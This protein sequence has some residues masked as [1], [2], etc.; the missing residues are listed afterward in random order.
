MSEADWYWEEEGTRRGPESA[1]DLRRHR[2]AGRIA[3]DTLVWRAGFADW[4]P[5]SQCELA[6]PAKKPPPL[7]SSRGSTPPPTPSAEG[8]LTAVPPTYSEPVRE[9]TP[10]PDYHPRFGNSLERAW[11]LWKTDFWPYV[12]M[13][14]LMSLILGLAAQFFVT[15]FFLSLPIMAG[16]FWW[17]LKRHRG[18]RTSVEDLFFGF[19]RRFGDLA[20]LNLILSVPAIVLVLP[21]MVGLVLAIVGLEEPGPWN[22]LTITGFLLVGI[23]ALVF[24]VFVNAIGAISTLASL[25]ILDADLPWKTALGMTWKMAKPRLARLTAIYFGYG[26]ISYLGIFVFYV[27]A[28]LAGTWS[29]TAL[30]LLYEDA[31]G[32]REQA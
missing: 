14:A 9:P 2:E 32:E 26:L 18:Q 13:Y 27:G 24:L 31:F 12:G 16:Y 25:L 7:R 1:D 6:E 17:V 29:W 22:S 10:N 15:L 28:F 23:G 19:K 11:A 4:I 20:V 8:A 5:W 3:P 21:P 30:V